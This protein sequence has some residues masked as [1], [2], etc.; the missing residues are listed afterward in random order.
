[1]VNEED[2]IRIM[3]ERPNF[4]STLPMSNPTNITNSKRNFRT[5]ISRPPKK[6]GAQTFEANVNAGLAAA[7]QIVAFFKNGDDRFRVNP[8]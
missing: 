3:E 6:S 5:D 2:L 1:M 4:R 8:K 7:R